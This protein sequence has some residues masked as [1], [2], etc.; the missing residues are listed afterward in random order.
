MAPQLPLPSVCT[1]KQ[2]PNLSPFLDPAGNESNFRQRSRLM[3]RKAL[4]RTKWTRMTR[5][6]VGK[7]KRTVFL[8]MTASRETKKTASM[9][10]LSHFPSRG[11]FFF[12]STSTP[13]FEVFYFYFYFNSFVFMA[14]FP[15][16]DTYYCDDTYPSFR[17]VFLISA[18]P[19]LLQ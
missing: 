11:G 12:I 6:T 10:F 1:P 19:L 15:L 13:P 5:T 9:C 14:T 17:G 7:V 16:Q 4:T 18:G 2:S 8:M 3:N